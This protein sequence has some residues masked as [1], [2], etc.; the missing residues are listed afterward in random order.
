MDIQASAPAQIMAAPPAVPQ[1]KKKAKTVKRKS[2]KNKKPKPVRE[3]TK[4]VA[5]AL[6]SL[7]RRLL[8]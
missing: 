6:A 7:T 2:Q 5:K 3:L 8:V 4:L 1:Q